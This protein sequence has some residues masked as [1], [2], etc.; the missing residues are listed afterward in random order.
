[1]RKKMKISSPDIIIF[2]TIAYLIT[3]FL[4]AACLF[5]FL[6]VI[7]GSFTPE[8][9]IVSKG[10][11]L[12]PSEL[13]LDAYKT[14]FK[15]PVVILRAYGMS[16][17][18]VVFGTAIGLFFTS[19]TGYVLH[20]KSFRYRNF[21]SFFF[22][23]TTLFSGGLVPW[24]ILIVN[25]LRLKNT[26]WVLLLPNLLSV[27][28]I[29]IMRTFFSTIPEEVAE[30]GK[31]DGAGEFTIFTRLMI[32]MVVPALA[33]VG[34]FIA[35]QYWNDWY[36]ANLF[37]SSNYDYLYPLQY[38]LYKVLSTLDFSGKLSQIT[39]IPTPQMP[40]ESFK[41]AMTVVTTGPIIFLYPFVQRFFIKG[42]TIG[43]VKG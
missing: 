13:S 33:T 8:K 1:M 38:F 30:S 25:Y 14:I 3:G 18:L 17:A 12:F 15:A 37:I 40:K 2:K 20:R 23:F 41:L 16:F 5:P 36:L 35:L 42:I 28:N 9:L 34:L 4:A 26:F 11:R 32:P 19:M 39:G 22:F 7:S 31:I 6:L 24:Y 43:T 27:F 21:F 10:Y 29:I